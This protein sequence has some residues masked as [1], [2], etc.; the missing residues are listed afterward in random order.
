MYVCSMSFRIIYVYFGKQQKAQHF[1]CLKR[2]TYKQLH[3]NKSRQI[4]LNEATANKYQLTQTIR[5]IFHLI[6]VSHIP[7]TES[8]NQVT[9]KVQV[10]TFCTS[11]LFLF[12]SSLTFVSLTLSLTLMGCN[13]E[14]KKKKRS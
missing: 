10:I 11:L 2:M 9:I 14:Q 12:S 6:T 3:I 13:G 5:I 7:N 1:H 4:C 8:R